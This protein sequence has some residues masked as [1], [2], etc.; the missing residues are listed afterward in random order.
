M[1]LLFFCV[2]FVE[3]STQTEI[4]MD[5]EMINGIFYELNKLVLTDQGLLISLLCYEWKFFFY[6][7]SLKTAFTQAAKFWYVAQFWQKI[8]SDWSRDQL[9]RFF[10]FF[11]L[12]QTYING[13][14]EYG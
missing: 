7:I 12:S 14:C 4:D 11:K 3:G 10:F 1:F 6:N 2:F 9:V 5:F 8:W 13:P